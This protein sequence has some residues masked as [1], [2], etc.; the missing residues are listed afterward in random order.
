MSATLPSPSR[1]PNYALNASEATLVEDIQFRSFRFFSEQT[2]PVSGLTH[3]RAPAN[4][5]RSDAPASIAAT[6]FALTAWCIADQRGWLSR[7]EARQRVLTT[8][9]FVHDHVPHA[10]GWIYHFID[11][12]TGQRAWKCEASTIDTALFLQ[13]ALGAR[14]YFGD[15]EV[16]AL[17]DAIY[18]RIDWRWALNGGTTLSHGW[19]PETGFIS[20]RWDS[21]AEM[22]GLYLLGIGAPAKALPEL[23]W[24]AWRRGPVVNYGGRTFIQCAPLFTHQYSHAW[25]DFRGLHDG[26][27]DYWQNSVDATLAQREWCA[28]RS[29]DFSHWSHELWGVTASD[30]PRGYRAWGGPFGAEHET[31]GTLVP[32]APG[33]SLPFAPRECLAALQKMRDLGGK[34]VWRRYG[35]ADAFNPQTGWVSPDVIGIDVGITLV[36]AE[37]L[38]SGRVWS[39]FMRA[40]EVRRGLQLA[41]FKHAV[42]AALNPNHAVAMG[43]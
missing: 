6:G 4:G 26:Y 12:K 11:A 31:D 24:H 21:Y 28:D 1:E 8:L 23:T 40:P 13:G 2:D 25:F 10:H 3:D 32:C 29:G 16:S 27:A 39:D 33:G 30:G 14:E 43:P 38:R 20:N 15:A 37:N 35:F 42:P 17:V 41:G 9:R 7:P 36:M 5:G 22:L 34:R 19:R 18:A